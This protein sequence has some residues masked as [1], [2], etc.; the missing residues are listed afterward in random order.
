MPIPYF[1]ADL[2]AQPTPWDLLVFVCGLI[3]LMVMSYLA[4]RQDRKDGLRAQRDAA[5]NEAEQM[6]QELART[7][8]VKA[9]IAA[10]LDERSAEVSRLADTLRYYQG[11]KDRQME[12][13]AVRLAHAEAKQLLASAHDSINGSACQC[14]EWQEKVADHLA[15][16]PPAK[17]YVPTE[18][19]GEPD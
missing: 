12:L 17:S 3:F 16:Y 10:L 8:K 1:A 2:T 6:R 14:R 19:T 4:G 15:K 5:R 11:I 13:Q 9:E 18:D 7:D